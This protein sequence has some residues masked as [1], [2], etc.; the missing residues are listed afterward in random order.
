[1]NP[2]I[3]SISEQELDFIA[4]LDYGRDREKHLAA[5]KQLIYGQNGILSET[6]F[7]YPYEVIELGSNQLQPGHEREF[8][9]CTLLIISAITAGTDKTK[10]LDQFLEEKSDYISS[11]PQDLYDSIVESWIDT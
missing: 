5:L 4:A 2:L 6:Q 10:D 3:Q 7:W 9:I 11:L 8:A 1:M